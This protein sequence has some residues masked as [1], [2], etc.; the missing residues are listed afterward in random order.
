MTSGIR[1]GVLATGLEEISNRPPKEQVKGKRNVMESDGEAN[2][3]IGSNGS[4]TRAPSGIVRVCTCMGVHACVCICVCDIVGIEG[5]GC[6][7]LMMPDIF[8]W[9]RGPSRSGLGLHTQERHRP[10]RAEYKWS[11]VT[12]ALGT[13]AG[14]WL[15]GYLECSVMEKT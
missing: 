10:L 7:A 2:V 3:T 14:Q 4:V 9:L 12:S 5:K 11:G 1:D 13:E 15:S 6:K 8:L